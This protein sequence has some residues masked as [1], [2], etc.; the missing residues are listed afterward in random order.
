M[1]TS[2]IGSASDGTGSAGRTPGRRLARGQRGFWAQ[3]LRAWLNGVSY[4]PERH[5]MRGRS[6][7][8]G[9]TSQARPT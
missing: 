4:H 6:S 1:T 9:S 8:A 3:R 2:V 7:D 5:Y